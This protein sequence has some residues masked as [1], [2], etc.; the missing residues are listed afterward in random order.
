MYG[1]DS[2]NSISESTYFQQEPSSHPLNNRE[3]QPPSQAVSHRGRG[4]RRR[5]SARRGD[6]RDGR[7]GFNQDSTDAR[8]PSASSRDIGAGYEFDRAANDDI[9]HREHASGF[10]D[11]HDEGQERRAWSGRG[12]RASHRR[13]SRGDRGAFSRNLGYGHGPRRPSASSHEGLEFEHGDEMSRYRPPREGSRESYRPGQFDQS[14]G[15]GRRRPSI[16]HIRRIIPMESVENHMPSIAPSQMGM[17]GQHVP[18]GADT[19]GVVGDP[20]TSIDIPSFIHPERARLISPNMEFHGGHTK[21]PSKIQPKTEANTVKL[22]KEATPRLTHERTPDHQL[23][24]AVSRAADPPAG[25]MSPRG[26]VRGLSAEDG[27]QWVRDSNSLRR[28][29]GRGRGRGERGQN[30]QRSGR[31]RGKTTDA[32]DSYRPAATPSSSVRSPRSPRPSHEAK[33][34]KRGT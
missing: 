1:M 28:G 17:L 6:K 5:A 12:H 27:H 32:R 23:E 11:D 30:S 26:A 24:N 2:S 13:V 22:V 14:Q 34:R 33:R 8:K 29:R 18:G 21:I 4:G 3:D 25:Q 10:V 20:G 7:G 19:Q 9:L 15:H 31:A 16:D